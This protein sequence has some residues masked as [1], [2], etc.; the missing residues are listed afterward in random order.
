LGLFIY[1]H[2]LALTLPNSAYL[3]LCYILAKLAVL[4][5]RLLLLCGKCQAANVARAAAAEKETRGKTVSFRSGH[6]LYLEQRLRRWL[7]QQL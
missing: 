1:L 4:S 7:R 3:V 6:I 5:Q 2:Y